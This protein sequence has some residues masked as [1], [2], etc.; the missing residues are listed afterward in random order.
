MLKN[1]KSFPHQG[2]GGA[3]N[4]TSELRPFYPFSRLK[5]YFC[6]GNHG[7]RPESTT[8]TWSSGLESRL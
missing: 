6:Y 8:I 5:R 1:Q 7:R 3:Q 4:I 2:K